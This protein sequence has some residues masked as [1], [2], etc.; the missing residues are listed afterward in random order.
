MQT[1]YILRFYHISII[2]SC[3]KSIFAPCIFIHLFARSIFLTLSRSCKH[4]HRT[5]LFYHFENSMQSLS[6]KIIQ[7]FLVENIYSISFCA[8][9]CFKQLYLAE[10]FCFLFIH[11]I[12][13][14]QM[15]FFLFR[16]DVSSSNFFKHIFSFLSFLEYYDTH[17]YCI[18]FEK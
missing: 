14:M 18:S 6:H 2:L 11:F 4:H 15:S 17:F 16:R 3:I 13:H 9:F 12:H 10:S 8:Q 5:S 7:T 1:Y